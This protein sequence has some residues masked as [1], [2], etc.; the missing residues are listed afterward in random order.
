MMKCRQ[1][2]QRCQGHIQHPHP[3]RFRC[4]PRHMG[5]RSGGFRASTIHVQARIRLEG[6]IITSLHLGILQDVLV[7]TTASYL[8]ITGLCA[9]AIL[10]PLNEVRA[11]K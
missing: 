2:G 4:P 7:N 6:K 5:L 3:Q 11:Q 1:F 8:Y 10:L 9:T